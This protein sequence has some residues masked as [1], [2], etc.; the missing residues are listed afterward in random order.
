MK[1]VISFPNLGDYYV[2]FKNFLTRT[3]KC[4]IMVP[5]KSTKKT[6]ELGNKYAPDFVCLPFKYTLGNFIESLDNGANVLIQAGGG[7][8]Y[9]YYAEVQEKILRDLG[10]EFDYINFTNKGGFS[11]FKFYKGL[12]KLNKK[13]NIFKFAYYLLVALI[14]I[15]YMD[16]L[17]KFIRKNISYEIKNGILLM[18]KGK[19]L[20]DIDNN[21]SVLKIR[22]LYRIT[23]NKLKVNINSKQKEVLKI[24]I[25]GELFSLM[26]HSSSY[27]IEEF[28]LNQNIEVR[29][30]TDLTCLLI[31]KRF[32]I[33]NILKKANSFTK[34]FQGADAT[35]NISHSIDM[36]NE[37]FDGII[38]MKPM[39]CSPEINAVPILQKV[40]K[41]YNIPVLFLTFD[42]QYAKGAIDTRIEAFIDMLKMRKENISER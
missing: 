21:F 3:S 22:K 10:Y 14:T 26:E 30:Y 16:K 19:F 20:K 36:A 9:G 24:G 42:S 40:S 41:K 2:V 39:S 29:R 5:L 32:Q 23:L 31:T 4:E 37:G 35:P 12:K 18:I 27:N 28:L 34:F 6:L 15:I 33:K 7:C 25:I 8:R 1:K 38:H 11:F 13:L 17:D